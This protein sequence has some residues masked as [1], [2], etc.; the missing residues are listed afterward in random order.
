MVGVATYAC[1]DKTHPLFELLIYVCMYVY[2]TNYIECQIKC[3]LTTK[4]SP[5]IVIQQQAKTVLYSVIVGFM[6][7]L[8]DNVDGSRTNIVI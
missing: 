2:L 6:T 3:C 8:W 5:K 4:M 7:K 1:I